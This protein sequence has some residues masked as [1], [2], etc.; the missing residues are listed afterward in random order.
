M[1]LNNTN[2]SAQ[3]GTTATVTFAQHNANNLYYHG[4]FHYQDQGAIT[5]YIRC[6]LS[7]G[8]IASGTFYFI[9][10]SEKLMA[11]IRANNNTLSSVTALPSA[12]GGLEI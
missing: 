12:T 11:I 9:W 3:G 2:N 10:D 4:I 8:N 5:D 7:S 1:Y 6:Y